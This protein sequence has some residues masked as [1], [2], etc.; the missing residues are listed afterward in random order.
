MREIAAI[1]GRRCGISAALGKR[2]SA[3][4]TQPLVQAHFALMQRGEAQSMFSLTLA[5]GADTT[6]CQQ[7]LCIP[8]S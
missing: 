5:G 6:L 4:S 8:G 2:F 3:C 7:S 1:L